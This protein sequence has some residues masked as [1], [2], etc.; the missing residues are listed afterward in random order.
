[1]LTKMLETCQ[2][3]WGAEVDIY[4][5]AK[6]F[7]QINEKL[8]SLSGATWDNPTPL[9]RFLRNESGL[10]IA[11]QNIRKLID[12]AFFNAYFGY[13]RLSLP[14]FVEYPSLWGWKDPRNTFSLPVWSK[15][16]PSMY[17]IHIV[18]NGI[19]VADS[20]WKREVSRPSAGD[21]HYSKLC[22]SIEGC[23][24]LW[25][26]YVTIA[27][28]NIAVCKNAIEIRFEDLVEQPVITLKSLIH[29]IGLQSDPDFHFAL[30][31]INP[32]KSF[33][34]RNNKNLMEF[35]HLVKT[36]PLFIE[37]GYDSR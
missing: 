33:A 37:L 7:Q 5:E 19:D 35:W 11:E 21:P 26:Y 4:N 14:R 23:F 13:G 10:K 30:R 24:S 20:L 12:T 6:C 25:K 34:F 8:L 9:F 36:D 2:I 15:I 28:Q 18:R 31:A 27:R 22:Q 29:F 17:V 32:D 3:F 1:M 16:F